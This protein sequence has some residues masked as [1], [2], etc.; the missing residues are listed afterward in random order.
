MRWRL[1][2]ADMAEETLDMQYFLVKV[3][4]S[5]ELLLDRVIKAADRGVRVRDDL[6]VDPQ[7]GIQG[8]DASTLYLGDYGDHPVTRGLD[9]IATLF[10]YSRS[11]ETVA[12]TFS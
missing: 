12:P 2:L 11:L 8:Y 5:G 4:A 7:R 1:L 3:D 6:V 9:G 10:L